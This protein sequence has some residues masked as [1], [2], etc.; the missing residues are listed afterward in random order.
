MRL[1]IEKMIYGGEGLARLPGNEAGP[2]KSVFVP[3]VLPGEQVEAEVTEEKRGFARAQLDSVVEQSPLRIHADCPYFQRCGGCHYQHTSYENQLTIKAE[4]LRETLRRTAKLEVP[5]DLQIHASPPWNYRNRARLKVQASP[6]FNLGYYKF[7]SHELLPIK[8][9]PISSPLINQAIAALWSKGHEGLLPDSLREIELFAN[10][11]D[12]ALLIEIYVSHGTS[13]DEAHQ[14]CEPVSGLL[15]HLRGVVAFESVREGQSSDP[16]KLAELGENSL[17]YSVASSSYKVSAG[18]FFQVNRFLLNDLATTVLSDHSGKLA[19]DLYAGGGLFSAVLAKRFAQV[20]AVEASQTSHAD[21]R[22]N[23]P[24]EVK[25]VRASADQFLAKASVLQPDLVIVDPPR[26]GVGENVVRGLESAKATH[27]TYVS[28][29][30]S[31]LA[32]DLRGL[33][34][35]GYRI[36]QAHLLDMFPQTFHIETV[37]HLAR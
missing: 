4:I 32:R 18:A 37:F 21:L 6:G 15:P 34:N 26:S 19:L 20:V 31:T 12:G 14:A 10:D 27:I 23:A 13:A 33:V 17:Q 24:P 30:P 2:G 29:D 22:H 28:C 16:K 25:A 1:N 8:Q 36:E 11:A 7:R 3:F 35:A 9:C 5:C